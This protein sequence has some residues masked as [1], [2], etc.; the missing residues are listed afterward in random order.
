VQGAGKSWI[1][2][3]R[4]NEKSRKTSWRL[5]LPFSNISEL[6]EIIS[7]YF[8]CSVSQNMQL[9]NKVN[10]FIDHGSDERK[11]LIRRKMKE[12]KIFL[13]IH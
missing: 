5:F 6:V 11:G 2:Q 3:E 4:A 13:L 7:N 8:L 10:I 9:K 1:E 12:H